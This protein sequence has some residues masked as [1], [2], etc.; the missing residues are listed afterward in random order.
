MRIFMMSGMGLSLQLMIFEAEQTVPCS[1]SLCCRV[2]IPHR[3]RKGAFWTPR[4]FEIVR[5]KCLLWA[6]LITQTEMSSPITVPRNPKLQA[7]SRLLEGCSSVPNWPQALQLRRKTS[8][9]SKVGSSAH[10]NILTKSHW[11]GIWWTLKRWQNA[12]PWGTSADGTKN[13]CFSGKSF[14]M[15]S[16]GM[17]TKGKS[18][19]YL[20]VAIKTFVIAGAWAVIMKLSHVGGIVTTSIKHAGTLNSNRDPLKIW[21]NKLAS[22]SA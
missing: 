17:D 9:L 15:L 8:Y 3:C 7:T 2:A 10:R 11:V 6:F 16:D 18:T 14:I 19:L 13:L 4:L 1:C 22:S 12:T 20:V 21:V 5:K